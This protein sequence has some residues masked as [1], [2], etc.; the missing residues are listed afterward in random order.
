MATKGRMILV[1]TVAGG[2]YQLE[3]RYVMSRRLQIR[4]TV[5]RARPL[6]EKIETTLA[7]AREVVPLFANG[8]LRPVI[9]CIFKVDEIGKAHER[10]ESNQT[11]GKVVVEF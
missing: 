6:E 1:G 7:F 8:A 11:V 10:L 5:L 2:S 9:D 3:S 4:G